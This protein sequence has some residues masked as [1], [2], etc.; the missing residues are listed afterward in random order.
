MDR[1]FTDITITLDVTKMHPKHYRRIVKELGAISLEPLNFQSYNGDTLKDDLTEEQ[2]K[3][4]NEVRG[5]PQPFTNK[6]R[7]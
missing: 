5:G 6:R 2:L 3:R 7:A 4:L 1:I